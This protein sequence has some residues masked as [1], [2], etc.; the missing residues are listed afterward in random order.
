M[1]SSMVMDGTKSSWVSI[2]QVDPDRSPQETSICKH[3]RRVGQAP[4]SRP[5]VIVAGSGAT[6]RPCRA[7]CGGNCRCQVPAALQPVPQASAPGLWRRWRWG[8]R[9]CGGGES[10]GLQRSGRTCRGFRCQ[11]RPTL[12]GWAGKLTRERPRSAHPAAAGTTA[13]QHQRA[14][15]AHSPIKPKW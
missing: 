12:V 11:R 10:P 14:A 3:G 9:G 1:V 6:G 15:Y 5:A 8:S 7:G 2:F 13:L 4:R